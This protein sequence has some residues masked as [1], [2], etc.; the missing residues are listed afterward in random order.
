[1][2]LTSDDGTKSVYH[3]QLSKVS[4]KLV[5]QG[6]SAGDVL[7]DIGDW[8]TANRPPKIISKHIKSIKKRP[9]TLS[10][11]KVDLSAE[12]HEEP[13]PDVAEKKKKEEP[14]PE[15]EEKE[16]P[17]TEEDPAPEAEKQEPAPETEKK[18]APAP[19]TVGRDI[20][21]SKSLLPP[22]PPLCGCARAC[23]WMCISQP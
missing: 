9:I 22:L 7:T 11:G 5:E 1:M 14:A 23:L 19:E 18:E 16:E 12:V 4:K 6:V 13:L 17:L 10:F 8:N 2:I 15:A 3:A 20:Y 21:L